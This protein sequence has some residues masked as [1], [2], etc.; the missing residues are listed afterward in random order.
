MIWKYK[1]EVK[2]NNNIKAGAF[3]VFQ[4]VFGQYLSVRYCIFNCLFLGTRLL[5]TQQVALLDLSHKI[6]LHIH[7]YILPE[8]FAHNYLR[9]IQFMLTTC[10]CTYIHTP[11]I[12]QNWVHVNMYICTSIYYAYLLVLALVHALLSPLGASKVNSHALV[13]LSVSLPDAFIHY[14]FGL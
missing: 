6:Y 10:V 14:S 9:V 1:I 2:L 13:P 12:V 8:R 11:A 3:A 4:A 7:M 5:Q